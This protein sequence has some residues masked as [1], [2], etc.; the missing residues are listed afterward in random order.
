MRYRGLLATYF[1]FMV[2]LHAETFVHGQF[3]GMRA[4]A[5]PSQKTMDEKVSDALE[6]LFSGEL[7]RPEANAPVLDATDPPPALDAQRPAPSTPDQPRRGPGRPPGP[8]KNRFDGIRPDGSKG[9][10]PQ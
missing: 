7:G 8:G 9:G 5:D 6:E 10:K 3:V 4:F 2:R 1:E